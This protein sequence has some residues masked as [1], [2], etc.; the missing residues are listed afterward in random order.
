MQVFNEEWINE[1]LPHFTKGDFR[2][3][4][5]S[6]DSNFY[7]ITRFVEH[8]DAAAVA[9]L[10][11]FHATEIRNMHNLL[12]QQKKVKDDDNNKDKDGYQQPKAIRVLDLCSSW[13]S[14]LPT[15]ALDMVGEV[16]GVGMNTEE[17]AANKQLSTFYTIDLN[18]DPSALSSIRKRKTHSETETETET[19]E[20]KDTFDLVL[21]QLSVDYLTNPV[22]VL[23]QAAAL[24]TPH[25]G[26]ILITFSNRVFIDKAV[27]IWT[28]KADIEHVN[29]VGDY[30]KASMKFQMPTT[31]AGDITPTGKNSRNGSGGDPLYVVSATVK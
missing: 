17:L 30:L 4:D 13:T 24:L 9:A 15:G 21:L 27:A 31:T 5:E 29:T 19:E 6:D 10:T 2:R 7:K 23:Q 14:H 20:I 8:I 22:Q 18:R 16:V 1:D 28:G 12:S 26:K 11:S 3:L 25:T